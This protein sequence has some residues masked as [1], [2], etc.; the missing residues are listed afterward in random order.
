M[1][2]KDYQAILQLPIGKV[3]I[4]ATQQHLLSID[5][6]DNKTALLKPK[7]TMAKET[8]EQL[9]CYFADPTYAFNVPMALQVK[10]FQQQV[11]SALQQIPIGKTQ[12]YSDLAKLL[13]TNPRPIGNACRTNPIPIIIPCHRV[14]AENGLGGYSGETT[15]RLLDIKRWLLQH[16]S[17]IQK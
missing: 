3:G 9:L 4:R 13:K 8:V 16:E 5:Y 11:L 2:N 1:E 12:T 14:I 7:T 17:S 6:V 10:P 15:G